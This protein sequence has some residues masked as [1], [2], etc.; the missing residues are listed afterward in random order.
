M[1]TGR[2]RK[3]VIG[4]EG[5]IGTAKSHHQISASSSRKLHKRVSPSDALVLDFPHMELGDDVFL[6]LSHPN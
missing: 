2:P 5:D 3:C 6:G 4:R 1:K